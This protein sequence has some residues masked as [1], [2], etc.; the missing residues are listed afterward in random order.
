MAFASGK[1]FEAALQ[2]ANRT[3]KTNEAKAEVEEAAPKPKR[4]RKS[5]A[6][7]KEE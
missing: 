5:R 1:E 4:K 7:K 6:K 3:A 2:K